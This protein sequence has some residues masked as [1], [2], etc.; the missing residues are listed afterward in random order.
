MWFMSFFVAQCVAK[1]QNV[2]VGDPRIW[3]KET[4]KSINIYDFYPQFDKQTGALFAT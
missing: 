1:K 4:S 3:Q 2:I